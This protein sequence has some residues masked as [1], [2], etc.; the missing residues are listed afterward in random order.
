MNLIKIK[1]RD[2]SEVEISEDMILNFPQGVFAFEDNKRF[3]LISPLGED[4]FPMWLQSV[5]TEA[6][7]FIV[8]DPKEFCPDYAVTLTDE[9]KEALGYSDGDSIEY[10]VIAVI[11]EQ[12]KDTTVNLKSPVVIDNSKKTAVQL[13]AQEAYP[14]RFPIFKKEEN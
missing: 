11:P 14:V 1:T 3:I 4:K 6:L 12:Y 10:L 7:C 13:I 5:D 9:A 8:F 2:F